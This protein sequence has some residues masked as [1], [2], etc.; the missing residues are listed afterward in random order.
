MRECWRLPDITVEIGNE[1]R[2]YCSFVTTADPALDGPSTV[3]LETSTLT[4]LSGYA[5]APIV[6][7]ISLGNTPARVV[8]IEQGELRLH[9]ARYKEEHCIFAPADPKF[10][11]PDELRHRLWRRLRAPTTSEVC[12]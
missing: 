11:N 12:V 4:D 1:L 2:A 7:A 9:R 10:L 3:T 6:H 8:L 5:T